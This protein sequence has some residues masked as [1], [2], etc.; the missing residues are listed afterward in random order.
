MSVNLGIPEDSSYPILINGT[1]SFSRISDPD[2]QVSIDCSQ[3]DEVKQFGAD[4]IL[5]DTGASLTLI[6][7]QLAA[8]LQIDEPDPDTDRWVVTMG[9]GGVNIGYVPEEPITL[10]VTGKHGTVASNDIYPV[11]YLGCAPVFSAIDEH[12]KTFNRATFHKAISQFVLVPY[13]LEEDK[14]SAVVAAPDKIC[15]LLNKRPC[16][17]D[18]ASNVGLRMI[19][20]GRDWQRKFKMAFQVKAIRID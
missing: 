9:V 13:Q 18:P 15:S 7:I 14:L 2:I 19:I 17:S 16:L 1:V 11:V 4:S 12:L 3:P 8:A 20:I 5:M 6:P 10:E